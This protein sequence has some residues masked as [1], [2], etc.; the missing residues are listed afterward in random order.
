MGADGE[1][2]RHTRYI[3]D[4]LD[5]QLAVAVAVGKGNLVRMLQEVLDE[6]ADDLLG[7]PPLRLHLR[8]QVHALEHEGSEVVHDAEHTIGHGQLAAAE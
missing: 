1:S 7:A 4:H 8:S 6:L 5:D 2:V 3:I